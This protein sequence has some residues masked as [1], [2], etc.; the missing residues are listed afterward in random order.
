MADSNLAPQ[1]PL[2]IAGNGFTIS[3]IYTTSTGF[4]YSNLVSINGYVFSPTSTVTAGTGV[5][6]GIQIPDTWRILTLFNSSNVSFDY[7]PTNP[8]QITFNNLL[9]SPLQITVGNANWALGATWLVVKLFLSWK[10]KV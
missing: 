6:T 4:T 9:T 10:P 1:A 2:T 3:G 7:T 5:F 8:T